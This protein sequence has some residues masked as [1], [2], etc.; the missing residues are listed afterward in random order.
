[1]QTTHLIFPC[2]VAV[3]VFGLANEQFEK[4]I[5]DVLTPLLPEWPQDKISKRVSRDGK[6]LSLTIPVYAT[7]REFIDKIYHAISACPEV[8]MA[9]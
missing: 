8:V 2:E 7:D 1:M 4:A 6:Y 9:L 3:K 5:Q